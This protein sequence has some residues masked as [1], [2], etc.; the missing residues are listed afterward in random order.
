MAAAPKMVT[1][2]SNL[3]NQPPD[4]L[5]WPEARDASA[6]E[7]RE[8]HNAMNQTENTKST[9]TWA[10]SKAKKEEK[11]ATTIC[12]LKPARLCLIQD[13]HKQP[14]EMQTKAEKEVKVQHRFSHQTT[15]R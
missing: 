8:M 2:Y 9:N 1:P 5:R 12:T 13:S 4:L 11:M 3:P 15:S 7:K 14:E 10:S 6:E